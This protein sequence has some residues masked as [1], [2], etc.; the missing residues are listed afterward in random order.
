MSIYWPVRFRVGLVHRLPIGGA[1]NR[2]K[3]S[4]NRKL[5]EYQGKK[6]SNHDDIFFKMIIG[7]L[8][9]KIITEL[10][11]KGVD[12]A[13]T[14]SRSNS[15]QSIKDKAFNRPTTYPHNRS[16]RHEAINTSGCREALWESCFF[17]KKQSQLRP[18]DSHSNALIIRRLPLLNV[19]CTKAQ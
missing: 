11:R 14:P 4:S 1:L 6:T 9:T 17:T 3:Y 19:S 8:T 12:T 18:R 13:M 2:A 15:K 7:N 16:L 5:P 10:L